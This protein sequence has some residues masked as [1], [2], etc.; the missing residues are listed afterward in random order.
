[1]G[2]IQ[3]LEECHIPAVASLYLKVFRK[4]SGA[5]GS[6]LQGYFREVFLQ[7]PWRDD[8]IASLVYSHKGKIV[9]FVGVI[10]RSMT[11]HGRPIRVAVVTQLMADT[12]EYRGFP[13]LELLERLF[14]GEQD[15][16][17]TDGATEAAYT[18]WT[19]AGAR[20]AQLYSLEWTR[21]LRH[22]RYLRAL[23][24]HGGN[25][26]IGLMARAASPVCAFADA[27][28]S[29]LPFRAVAP[30]ASEYRSD[31]AG[32]DELLDCI[33]EIGWKDALAPAYER[34]S[35]G[36]LLAQATT[37]RRHGDL[38]A[39]TVRDG[40]GIRAGWYVYWAKRGG[41]SNVLQ[42]G[43][44]GRH[45]DGVFR[46]LL[47]DAWDQGVIAVRG[48]AIPRYLSTM[49]LRHA[50]FRHVGHGVLIHSR[51]PKILACVLQGEAALSRLDG[52]WWLRFAVEE[53]R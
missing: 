7:N 42:I 45:F 6:D 11:F 17:Y 43:A 34:E 10:P 19:A 13:G 18:I 31:P 21:V 46:A 30:P 32:A 53:W 2:E 15:C 48:Q 28:L 24:E 47:R 22:S 37:A 26:R 9:G 3:K 35:F 40:R 50:T 38:R 4:R 41:I 5:A 20:A 1:M 12:E 23:V 52:E 33:S 49:T 36:W 51:D 8:S 44:K 25:A 39:A 27:V 14:Q 16:S 29:K